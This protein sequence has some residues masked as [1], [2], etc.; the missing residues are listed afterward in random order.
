MLKRKNRLYKNYKRHG[1]RD[2]DGTRLETFR[3]E[4]K[5][6]VEDSK[7]SYLTKLG[8]KV[9]DPNTTQ[10]LYWKIINRV[11]N[12]C[13]APKIPPLLVANTFILDCAKKAK[14]FNDFFTE[15]CRLIINIS[16][17]PPLLFH[18][19]KRIIS[20]YLTMILSH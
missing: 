14:L 3:E 6:A 1:Y 8:N 7:L 5:K 9:D 12:K 13:R 15:Q 18:T 17:L 4:C 2:H 20:L 10:K 11:M 16:G 19:N